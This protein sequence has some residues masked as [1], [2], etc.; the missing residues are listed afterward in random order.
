MFIDT[1][2]GGSDRR[3]PEFS[4]HFQVFRSAPVRSDQIRSC[5]GGVY[6]VACKHTRVIH[7]RP[8]HAGKTFPC[9]PV[10]IAP[11]T[12]AER[13][14]RQII[15]EVEKALDKVLP[16]YLAGFMSGITGK[17]KSNDDPA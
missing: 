6:A 15:S 3:R 1:I 8:F 4:Q 14:I 10:Q 7:K 11:H 2:D 5:R 12:R 13:F 9:F 17:E 16:V